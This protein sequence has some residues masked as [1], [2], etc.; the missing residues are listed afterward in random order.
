MGY[1]N[2]IGVY[3]GRFQPVHAGHLKSIATALEDCEKVII[4]LGSSNRARTIRNPWTPEERINFIKIGLKEWFDEPLNPGWSDKPEPSIL[5]RVQFVTLRDYMYNNYKWVSEVQ[6]NI[7]ELGGSVNDSKTV[8]YG[9]HKDDTSFYLEL[10][11]FWARKTLPLYYNGLSSTAIRESLFANGTIE[12]LSIKQNGPI[13]LP[14]T[15]KL[16]EIL[17][18]WVKSPESRFLREEWYYYKDYSKQWASA[19][20]TPTFVTV[21]SLVIRSGCILLIKR[22]FHPGKGLWALP[23]GFL[24]ANETILD[25]AVRELKEET[26]LAVPIQE[27]KESLKQSKVFDHPRRSLRGRTI[28]H[29]HEFYLEGHGPLPAVKQKQSDASGAYWV[30]ISSLQN[31]EDKF[32]EDHFDIIFNLISKY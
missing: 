31:L 6:L 27:L 23:G 11:P 14:V 10:F 15:P 5:D 4:V 18:A 26:G 16:K 2:K 17:E 24:E 20:Y 7:A 8:I 9:H 19:P 32:F 22:G 13:I 30:P 21:D 28:T 1:P 29:A 25:S 3:I 12:D